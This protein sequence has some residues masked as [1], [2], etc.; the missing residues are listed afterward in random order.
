[1]EVSCTKP[2][3]C[4]VMYL[5]AR[6]ISFY[7]FSIECLEMFRHVVFFVFHFNTLYITIL[8]TVCRICYLYINMSCKGQVVFTKSVIKIKTNITVSSIL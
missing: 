7:D 3:R 2:G 1:M 8:V 5:F 6:G 4:A